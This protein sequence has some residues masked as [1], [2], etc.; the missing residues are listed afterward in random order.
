[1]RSIESLIAEGQ[2]A[3]LATLFELERHDVN[4]LRFIL[5][6]PRLKRAL[7]HPRAVAQRIKRERDRLVRRVSRHIEDC[8]PCTRWFIRWNR[9]ESE[10][11]VALVSELER[12]PRAIKCQVTKQPIIVVGKKR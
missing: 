1:M 6:D 10:Q 2:L 9:T 12:D 8:E 7:H 11:I 5:G 4:T 3:T